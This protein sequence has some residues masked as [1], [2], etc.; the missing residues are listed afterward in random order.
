MVLVDP[1]ILP[2]PANDCR[3]TA[4]CILLFSYF[5][6][7]YL[8]TCLYVYMC[9]HLYGHAYVCTQLWSVFGTDISL[10]KDYFRPANRPGFGGTV[11]L[12]Y[13]MSRVPLNHGNVPLFVRSRICFLRARAQFATLPRCPD[14]NADHPGQYTFAQLRS[15]FEYLN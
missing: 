10:T 6:N 4:I 7:A 8:V 11:P 9:V 5:L 13:P 12:F 1:T 14:V 15:H 3:P 2:E